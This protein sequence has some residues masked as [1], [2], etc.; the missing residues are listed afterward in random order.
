MKLS[1][2]K[3]VYHLKGYDLVEDSIQVHIP[4]EVFAKRV[5]KGHNA[6]QRAIASSMDSLMPQGET[7]N[8]RKVT[9]G[10]NTAMIGTKYVYAAYG[11]PNGVPYGRFQYGGKVMVGEKNGSPWA[12][13][14]DRKKLTDRP[15]KYSRK[16]A[17]PKW[18]AAA[19][20]R[21]MKDW[22]SAA[23]RA[24]NGG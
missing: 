5:Q 15:L 20:K 17:V 1:T 16:E 3:I 21:D 6:L 10:A 9:R 7:G 11:G 18:Y 13:K 14:D 2:A 8:L 12:I 4:G 19:K 24:M 23:E 22:I